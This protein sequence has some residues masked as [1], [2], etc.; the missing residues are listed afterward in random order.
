MLE[1]LPARRRAA[2]R[3]SSST[4]D[5]WGALRRF[6]C[7][8]DAHSFATLIPDYTS[9]LL[10]VCSRRRFDGVHVGLVSSFTAYAP[11]LPLVL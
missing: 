3:R 11:V 9:F 8:D 10:R 7:G 1:N 5:V 2:A 4:S 6:V